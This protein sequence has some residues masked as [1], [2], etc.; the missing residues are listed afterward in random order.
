MDLDYHFFR[1]P[2]PLWR[3]AVD[4]RIKVFVGE[5]KVPLEMEI[6]EYDRTAL[7]L[8][9]RDENQA[10]VGTLRIVIKGGEGKIGRV[11]VA[12]AYRHRGIGTEMMRLA[13]E[14]CR[15]QD[16]AAVVLDAQA[17]IVPFYQSLGFLPEGET[18]MDAGIPHVRMR[19][20]LR[21][22]L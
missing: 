21:A 1:L 16:L 3:A 19:L 14:H 4:L 18:F 13:V 22:Y 20:A 9:A 8:L 12:A 17:Y 11:A 15:A 2:S 10:A 7:H 5:Q 6:D